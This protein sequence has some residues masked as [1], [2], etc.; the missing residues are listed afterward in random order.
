MK[1]HSILILFLLAFLHW[2]C[3]KEAFV[4][5]PVADP[6][7]PI[8]TVLKPITQSLNHMDTADILTVDSTF[9][10]LRN[11]PE[12]D[13]LKVGEILFHYPMAS[14]KLIGGILGKIVSIED[15]GTRKIFHLEQTTIKESFSQYYHASQL[16]FGRNRDACPLESNGISS[17]DEMQFLSITRSEILPFT[18]PTPTAAMQN[19]GIS[20][21]LTAGY[22]ACIKTTHIWDENTMSE[23]RIT[24]NEDNST[25]TVEMKALKVGVSQSFNFPPKITDADAVPFIRLISPT[26]IPGLALGI[27][28]RFFGAIKA[29]FELGKVFKLVRRVTEPTVYTWEGDGDNFSKEA[30]QKEVTWEISDTLKRSDFNI[31]LSASLG[32]GMEFIIAFPVLGT[33]GVAVAPEVIPVFS[34]TIADATDD[35]NRNLVLRFDT[36]LNLSMYSGSI[37]PPNFAGIR[38]GNLFN[39]QIKGVQKSDFI[40]LGHGYKLSFNIFKKVIPIATPCSD[41][42]LVIQRL[43][44]VEDSQLSNQKILLRV[45]N[46]SGNTADHF[47]LRSLNGGL[48]DVPADAQFAFNSD[49]EIELKN[50]LTQ[51]QVIVIS[52]VADECVLEASIEPEDAP[53]ICTELIKDAN[54]KEYCTRL[55]GN[56]RW[57][58]ENLDYDGPDGNLG[59]QSIY[60][61]HYSY[62]ELALGNICPNGY[63]VPTQNDFENLIAAV[64]NPNDPNGLGELIGLGWAIE[65][66]PNADFTMDADGYSLKTGNST[67]RQIFTDGTYNLG[68]LATITETLDETSYLVFELFENILLSDFTPAVK[69][70]ISS[71]CRCVKES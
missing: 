25:L 50:K 36:G 14:H 54:D 31:N 55:I 63:R 22:E 16:S 9:I 42:T 28:L 43:G 64:S 65:Q 69:Q 10:A 56:T 1:T 57:M 21:N 15:I 71:P 51:L 41:Q 53:R 38:L 13:T 5:D 23:P 68:T 59:V 40:K 48:V 61:R 60:G 17:L 33:L 27:G 2:N 62:E 34:A 11:T 52:L 24:R 30:L 44:L 4:V 66:L 20:F 45:N 58:V 29:E 35:I 12:L 47:I 6:N 3:E 8:P 46:P 67:Y 19:I 37:F 7:A 18:V 32:V 26:P 39:T 70:V 49:H